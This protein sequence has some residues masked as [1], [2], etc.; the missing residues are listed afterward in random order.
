[1]YGDDVPFENDGGWDCL[2]DDHDKGD[3]RW[4][5]SFLKERYETNNEMKCQE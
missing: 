3:R 1:M 2:K 5:S 4:Q